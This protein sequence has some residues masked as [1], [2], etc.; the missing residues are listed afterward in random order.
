[1]NTSADVYHDAAEARRISY[2]RD[3][4]RSASVPGPHATCKRIA[5]T[6]PANVLPTGKETGGSLSLGPLGRGPLFKARRVPHLPPSLRFQSWSHDE[7]LADFI[8]NCLPTSASYE[9]PLMW[10]RTLVSTEKEINALPLAMSALAVGWAGHTGNEP[11]LVSKGLQLYTTALGQLKHELAARSQLQVLA[12]TAIFTLYELFE[13]GPANS[14]GWLYHVSAL[15]G[16]LRNLGPDAV[17]REPY[18]QIFS[19]CRTI[20]VCRPPPMPS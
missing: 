14:R 17:S 18:L 4:S 16:T 9:V 10:I 1:L 12:T 7:I 19:F 2:T 3:K 6:S 20:Y 5:L 13:F 15:S 8:A 11:Q